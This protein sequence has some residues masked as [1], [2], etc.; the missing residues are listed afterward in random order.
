ML[1]ARAVLLAARLKLF[2]LAGHFVTSVA[3]SSRRGVLIGGGFATLFAQPA[4]ATAEPHPDRS[5]APARHGG[6]YL[7]FLA[8]IGYSKWTEDNK[9]TADPYENVIRGTGL[10]VDLAVGGALN[11]KVAVFGEITTNQIAGEQTGHNLRTDTLYYSDQDKSIRGIGVGA[12][13]FLPFSIYVSGSLYLIPYLFECCG[14]GAYP[15]ASLTFA[16]EWWPEDAV[17]FGLGAKILAA[18]PVTSTGGDTGSEY[19]W[20][21]VG[22]SLV[23]S[24]TVN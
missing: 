8:G 17:G 10:T 12:A 2:V 20:T 4:T 19:P 13:Y 5:M 16:K 11:A 7:R 6:L 14:A 24:A 18:R 15:A 23:L 1:Y 21:A 22:G 3:S 9:E